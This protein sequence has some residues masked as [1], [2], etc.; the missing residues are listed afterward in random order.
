MYLVRRRV[1]VLVVL[2]TVSE[3]AKDPV[4][5][6]FYPFCKVPKETKNAFL[7]KESVLANTSLQIYELLNPILRECLR[8]AKRSV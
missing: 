3:V 1:L 4:V 5:Y 7:G 2:A 6:L 8:N